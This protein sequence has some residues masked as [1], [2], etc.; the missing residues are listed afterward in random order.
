VI[1]EKLYNVITYLRICSTQWC[2]LWN[3]SQ[4]LFLL[5]SSWCS[6]FANGKLFYTL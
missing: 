3:L 1:S 6:A 5:S 2:N 4:N